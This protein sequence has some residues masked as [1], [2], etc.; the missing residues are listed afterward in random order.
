MA[1]R[2]VSP[3]D[4]GPFYQNPLERIVKRF[5]YDKVCEHL[6]PDLFVSATNVRTGKI[7]VFETDEITSEVLMASACLP[8]LFQAVEFKDPKTG[9]VEAFWD[10]GYTG[11][12]ALFPLFQDHLPVD[13]VVVNINPLHRTDVPRTAADIQNRINEISFNSS[14]LRELRAI[15]FVKRLIKKGQLDADS[16]RDVLVHMIADDEMMTELSVATKTVPSALIL[17]RLKGAGRRAADTF[18]AAHKGDLNKRSSVVLEDMFTW[19]AAPRNKS[20][21]KRSAQQTPL[22]RGERGLSRF[23]AS[24]SQQQRRQLRT[25]SAPRGAPRCHGPRPRCRF[26]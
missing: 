14:L 1:S 17:A 13:V 23:L 15:N 7:R 2:V 8:T 12:P 5:A 24:P 25:R 26:R 9:E 21:A 10:G 22:L 3:Y 4:Y 20:K 6:G 19:R 18:L 11:N 16:M